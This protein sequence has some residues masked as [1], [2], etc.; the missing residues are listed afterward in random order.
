MMK[1]QIRFDTYIKYNTRLLIKNGI[2][3]NRNNV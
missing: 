2:K 3:Q 1:I